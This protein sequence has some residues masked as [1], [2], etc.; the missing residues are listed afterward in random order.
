M[1]CRS[2]SPSAR[3]S[4]SQTPGLTFGLEQAKDVVLAD[5][6]LDVTDDGTGLV[7][8]EL[9]TALGD[10][11]TRTGSAKDTGDLDELDGGLSCIHDVRFGICDGGRSECMG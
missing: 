11:T 7:V 5:R 2:S 9:D 8:H 10:T 1:K 3:G 6:A 4:L